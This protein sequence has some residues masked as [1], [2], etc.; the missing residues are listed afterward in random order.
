MTPPGWDAALA[1]ALAGT[2][3]RP[4]TGAGGDPERALLSSVAALAVRR[5]AGWAPP[6][7]A[8]PAGVPC[9]AEERRTVASA[10]ALRLD[11]MLGGDHAELLPEWLA[12]AGAGGL[13]VPPRLLPALL[14][15]AESHAQVREAVLEVI[16]RR[17]R[18]LA[19]RVP[20]WAFAALGDLEAA[21]E[22]GT[23]TAR[24]AALRELRRQ[25][26]A[27]ALDRLAASWPAESGEDRAALVGCL[28]VGLG[29]ADEAF[30]EA[31]TGDGR[32][33]VRQTALTFLARLPDSRLVRRMRERVEPMVVYRRGLLGGKLQVAPPERCGPELVADGVEPKPPQGIGEQAW[34]LSQ[35]LGLVPPRTWPVEA[36][37][38]AAGGDWTAALLRG[39]ALGAARFRDAR[40]AAALVLLWVGTPDK[41]RSSLWFDPGD[42]LESLEPRDHDDI[43]VRV[44]AQSAADGAALAANRG[45]RWG[46][47][48]T[49]ALLRELPGLA[50]SPQ[51]VH[52]AAS[53]AF[54]VG[55]CGDTSVLAEAER[56]A[57]TPTGIPLLDRALA[58]AADTLNWR[59]LMAK[60]LT[61]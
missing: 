53:A 13:V 5:L 2:A 8:L 11:A 52:V 40:W 28:D 20:G 26:P 10:A 19:A 37:G 46:E 4:L 56:L 12:L 29:P 17:G 58:D 39:W 48:L 51:K 42:I 22:T 36:A 30:L 31:A 9:P 43:L 60:E 21:F 27:A 47:G 25:D 14:A 18:W 41:R 38:A 6:R 61:T 57:A 49:R 3:R 35:M 44:L 33:E 55:R 23:R 15:H 16:G 1:S 32:K 54:V 34:W 45:H 24:T 50:R 59:A 7:S